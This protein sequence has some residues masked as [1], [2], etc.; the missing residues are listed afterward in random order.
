L[1]ANSI[2]IFSPQGELCGTVFGYQ[3]YD[4]L[5][6]M[7]TRF[8]KP[9]AVPRHRHENPHFV[10]VLGGGFE[11]DVAGGAHELSPGEAIF[12]E[13]GLLHEGRVF[14]SAGRGFVVEVTG[15]RSCT[16]QHEGWRSILAKIESPRCL[17]RS[18]ESPGFK[19]RR[20]A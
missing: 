4:R 13:A 1:P 2:P 6:V 5:F 20:N 15:L 12:Q 3:S 7:E 16:P 14:T 10:L 17:H 18:T 8:A 9:T 19:I 11:F